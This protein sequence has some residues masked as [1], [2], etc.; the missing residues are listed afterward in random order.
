MLSSR[1]AGSPPGVSPEYLRAVRVWCRQRARRK[2]E[3]VK[4]LQPDWLDGVPHAQIRSD[5]GLMA[6]DYA[7]I[8]RWARDAKEEAKASGGTLSF[9]EALTR[10]EE[11]QVDLVSRFL[12][13]RRAG[14]NRERIRSELGLSFDGY[15][16]TSEWLRDAEAAVRRDQ[17]A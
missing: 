11:R 6:D 5:H 8:R 16:A 7:R 17:A 13:L 10:H 9:E 1:M 3:W 2:S 4:R 12:L 15:D 14:A